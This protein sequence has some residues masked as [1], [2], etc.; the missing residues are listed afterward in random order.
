MEVRDRS[1]SD[2]SKLQKD[3]H[4]PLERNERM[5]CTVDSFGSA[6]GGTSCYFILC[7]I[8]DWHRGMPC[9]WQHLCFS[10]TESDLSR[11]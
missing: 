8:M 2:K 3:Q 1:M 6:G 5:G 10:V 4:Y 7:C 9:C 11:N